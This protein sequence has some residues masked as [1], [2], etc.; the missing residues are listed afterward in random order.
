MA[1][2]ANTT[3]GAAFLKKFYSPTPI[4]NTVSKKA[5]KLWNLIKH[6]S[7]GA[8]GSDYNFLS[9]VSDNP[10]GSATM[11][12]AQA[13]GQNRM[14]GG[15]KF[16]VPYFDD[17][18]N[19]TVSGGLI[20]RTRNEKG[21]WLKALKAEM[22]SSLRYAA[23]RKSIALYTSGWGELG[24]ISAG[25][26][27]A[28]NICTLADISQIYRFIPGMTIVFS[29]SL[30]ANLLRN[31]GGVTELTVLAVNYSTGTFTTAAVGTTT[32]ANI[33][34]VTNT[35]AGDIIFTSGDRQDSATPTLLRPVGLG[36]PLGGGWAP[37]V[38]PT[39]AENFFGVDRSVNSF[40]TSFYIDG[41]SISIGQ[42]FVAAAQTISSIGNA[43]EMIGVCS[44]TVFSAL[45]LS[46][47]Q[48]VPQEVKGKNGV[49]Y[50]TI[51]I[52]ADGIEL[53]VISDKYCVNGVGYVLNPKAMKHTSLGEAPQI[54]DDDGNTCLRLPSDDGVEVRIRSYETLTLENT[55]QCATIQFA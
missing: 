30:N 34:T 47:P 29:A 26:N 49:S 1:T 50:K 28:T 4:Q 10:S 42:A 13:V 44:P 48:T 5:S 14:Q 38:A 32:P 45:A 36:S 24:Q 37:L 23:H 19:P 20:A 18:E 33:N 41:R 16:S 55:A 2:G 27:V 35:V 22:D 6:D 53:P 7:G 3:T 11:S 43:D 51:V 9:I 52:F 21:G 46:L 12:K 25:T 15:Y 17:F 39:P 54:A 40:L 31:S 8:A